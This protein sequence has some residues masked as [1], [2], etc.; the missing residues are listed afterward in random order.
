MARL[1]AE[2]VRGMM[3]AELDQK[4]HQL[5]EELYKIRVEATTGRIE[6][7]HRIREVKKN[8]A[9]CHTIMRERKRGN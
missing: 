9:L 8:I 1:K 7:P 4:V 6:K 5:K 3:D 2:Q